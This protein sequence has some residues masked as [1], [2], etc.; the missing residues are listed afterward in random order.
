[1]GAELETDPFGRALLAAGVPAETIRAWTVDP[2][3]AY[4][5]GSKG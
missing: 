3:V 4:Q 2:V 5:D 1:M